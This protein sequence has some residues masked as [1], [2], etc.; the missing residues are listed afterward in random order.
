MKQTTNSSSAQSVPEL[1]SKA[2]V[3]HGAPNQL[4]NHPEMESLK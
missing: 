2:F 4:W 3:Q 1:R